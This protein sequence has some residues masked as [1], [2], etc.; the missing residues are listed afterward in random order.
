MAHRV[1]AYAVLV[2]DPSP[3]ASV[4]GSIQ[5]PVIPLSGDLISGSHTYVYIT[6]KHTHAHN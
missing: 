5:L 2:E 3:A 1:R 4:S 6:W